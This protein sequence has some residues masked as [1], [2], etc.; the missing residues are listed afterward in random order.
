[1]NRM[2]KILSASLVAIAGLAVA[3][4]AMEPM[5]A[6]EARVAYMKQM[7]AQLGVLGGMAQ[8]QTAYDAA[9]AVEAANKLAELANGDVSGMWP[10]GSDSD[11]LVGSRALP[12]IWSDSA[13]VIAKWTALGAGATAM[14]AAAGVDLASLQAA[15][16]AVGGACGS[17][18]ESYRKPG[19]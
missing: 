6:H 5:A 13:G 4:T 7:G 8:G 16:G 1:M 15:M 3:Q 11:T 19:E 17:C 12:A 18:H 14:Q 9:A 10:E 2:T